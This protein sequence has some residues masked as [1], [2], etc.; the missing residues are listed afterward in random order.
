M[1]QEKR[2]SWPR[3]HAVMHGREQQPMTTCWTLTCRLMR[4]QADASPKSR[5]MYLVQPPA[6]CRRRRRRQVLA[7]R[8]RRRP[9]PP[10]SWA[11]T[12]SSVLRGGRQANKQ[13]IRLAA[14]SAVRFHLCWPGEARQGQPGPL[15]TALACSCNSGSPPAFPALCSQSPVVHSARLGE[16]VCGGKDGTEDD[17]VVGRRDLVCVACGD[18]LSAETGGHPHLRGKGQRRQCRGLG[19]DKVCLVGVK[20]SLGT[21]G[22]W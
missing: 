3:S 10:P 5:P 15:E 9:P 2:T 8:S 12:V 4:P 13:H 20:R 17:V 22:G 14:W 16:A 21:L 19:T 11:H 1:K 6:P 7:P 18:V